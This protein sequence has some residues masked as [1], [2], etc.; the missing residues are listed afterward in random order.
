MN[1]QYLT[2]FLTVAETG[3]FTAAAEKLGVAQPAL[4]QAIAR[5]EK[6]MGVRL[7]V[8][9]RRGAVLTPP[10]EAILHDIQAG[11]RQIEAACTH[12]REM[13]EGKVG[14]LTVGFV[15]TALYDILPT[16]MRQ[17][18]EKGLRM[19][20]SFV[21]MS[22]AEQ[23]RALQKREIDIGLLFTPSEVLGNMHQVVL[24][25]DRFIAAV[26]ANYPIGSDGKVS[27]VEVAEQG[28]IFAPREQLPLMRAQILS[29]IQQAGGHGY[30]VQEAHRIMNV[31]AFVA[32]NRGVSILPGST[33]ALSFPGV[34]FCELRESGHM[35]LVELSAV[36]PR[37]SRPVL[38][39][40]FAALLQSTQIPNRA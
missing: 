34:K 28:L 13:A 35:P 6:S 9:S 21:E 24:L 15:A 4:S 36:W 38:A 7:F 20:L 37:R 32:G 39:D 12:A 19:D 27:L 26:P 8:R 2:Y 3:T 11:V 10:G 29:A 22:N 30:V 40:T 5:M 17:L 18:K 31:L 16:V 23:A 1:L 14:K 33:A 25:Q